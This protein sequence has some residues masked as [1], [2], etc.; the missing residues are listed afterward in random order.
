M[1]RNKPDVKAPLTGATI[2][3]IHTPLLKTKTLSGEVSD[4]ADSIG[5]PLMPWQRFVFDDFCSVSEDGL[6]LKKLTGVMVARQNGKTH[7]ARM[8]ILAG[9]FLW[10]EK[11]IVAMSHTRNLAWDTF[12]QVASA[13]EANA[14][15]S[16]AVKAIR[17]SNGTE[18][19]EL[20]N[21][22][23]YEIVAASTGGARGK[24]ADFLYID[25]TREISE[26]AWRAARPV[27]I[28]RRNAQTLTTSNSGT[29][30]ST[31]LNGL[32]EQAITNPNPSLG[33]YEYSAPDLCRLD[34]RKAWAMANPALNFTITEDV[35]ADLLA[36][37][38]TDA[39]RTE[40]LCQFVS[41]ATSPWPVGSL[42]ATE[43]PEI[44]LIEGAMTIM[45]FD[46]SPN[47]RNASLVAGQI[48]SLTGKIKVGIL[49]VWE[50]QVSVDD[51]KIAAD[52]KAW[53]DMY[54]PRA[55]CYDK[56]A[57]ASIAERLA[58][59]GVVTEEI[60]A[61][62]FYQASGDLLDALVNKRIAHT[63]DPLWIASMNNA[64]AKINDSAW[65]VVKRKSAGD[66]S[67]CISTCMIVHML[68]KPQSTPQIIVG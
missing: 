61:Q 42:E 4:L 21:G 59:S 17:R 3:R 22:A 66:I 9:L 48:D 24:T 31:V 20:M 58:N 37:S 8:R 50:S 14:H 39:F 16:K 26:D 1:S 54:R 5:V 62:R 53:T 52:I 35:I 6:W 38:T 32:R 13:I 55:V 45:A 67:A 28:A 23:V 36:T 12:N 15:L 56:Y 29:A 68:I 2:P 11:N 40:N 7:L 43:D 49:Q 64:A 19:I 30:F 18:S 41:S 47:R 27:T 10:N 44:T 33:W 63:G 65:R 60:S 51:L 57:T 25:E 46:V 34:D